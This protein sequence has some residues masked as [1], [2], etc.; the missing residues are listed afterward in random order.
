MNRITEFVDSFI[1]KNLPKSR[2]VSLKEELTCHLLDKKDYYEKIGY[3][4][5]VS[6][7]KAIEDFGTDEESSN[8]IYGEFEE[9]YSEKNIFAVMA[10]VGIAVMNIVC[11]FSGLFVISGDFHDYPNP[12][13]ACVSFLIIF[14]VFL[15]IALAR[16]KKYRKTLIAIGVANV[17]IAGSFLMSIYPQFASFTLGFNTL[18]FI[19]RFTPYSIRP[20]IDAYQEDMLSMALN[21]LFL[22]LPALYCFIEAARIRKGAARSV[23]RP[24]IKVAVFSTLFL[25]LTAVSCFMLTVSEDY[26][27]HYPKWFR[28][29]GN[30]IT[31]ES[32]QRFDEI[33]IGDTYSEVCSRLQSSGYVTID[34]Y[35]ASLDKQTKKQFESEMQ[36]Y[37][38]ADGYEIWF[39]PDREP[40]YKNGFVGVKQKN[41]IITAKGVGNMEEPMQNVKVTNFGDTFGYTNYDCNHDMPAMLAY[42][43]ALQKDDFETDVMG[44][45]GEEFGIVYAKRISVENDKTEHYYRVYCHG[46]MDANTNNEEGTYEA[47]MA[48]D[49][50][51]IELEF[52]NGMLTKGVLYDEVSGLTGSTVVT[53]KVE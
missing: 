20:I 4:E 51:Y 40:E 25:L 39:N 46:N 11:L 14:A 53:E 33:T 5:S 31:E 9:L 13:G 26:V 37:T 17:L 15:M 10:F 23:K 8:Y 30:G 32:Q 1:P 50:R 16:I 35:K 18:Y 45:F 22:L 36:K 47:I 3:D 7:D 19:D 28:V 48:R 44:R 34:A 6:I 27:R 41:G 52:E 42:F 29:G 12:L 49:S 38:F 2:A 21:W 43:R 24:K